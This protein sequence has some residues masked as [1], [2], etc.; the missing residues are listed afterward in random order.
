MTMRYLLSRRRFP[1]RKNEIVVAKSMNCMHVRTY[2]ADL[3]TGGHV[4]N[5]STR[6]SQPTRQTRIGRENGRVR[7]VLRAD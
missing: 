7:L 4:S 5:T 3:C 1:V 2:V 6:E